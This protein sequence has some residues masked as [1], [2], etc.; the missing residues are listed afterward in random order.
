MATCLH[1]KPIKESE[2]G[3]GDTLKNNEQTV[4]IALDASEQAEASVKC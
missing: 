2:N 3:D 4:I 1:N